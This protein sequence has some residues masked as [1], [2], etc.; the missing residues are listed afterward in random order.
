MDDICAIIGTA[1]RNRVDVSAVVDQHFPTHESF[2]AWRDAGHPGAA[3]V[4]ET[5]RDLAEALIEIGLR[6]GGRHDES[7]EGVLEFGY[8][9]DAERFRDWCRPE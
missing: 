4:L 5:R 2:V 3:C 7:S 9:I 8:H 6:R 1:I